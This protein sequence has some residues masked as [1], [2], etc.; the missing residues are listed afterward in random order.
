MRLEEGPRRPGRE[1]GGRRKGRVAGRRSGPNPQGGHAPAADLG[2]PLACSL[3][4]PHPAW[5]RWREGVFGSLRRFQ[6]HPEPV[7]IGVGAAA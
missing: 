3:L 4:F 2:G 5:L 1:G 6:C 7:L